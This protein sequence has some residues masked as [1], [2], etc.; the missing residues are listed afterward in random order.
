[1]PCQRSKIKT[2]KNPFYQSLTRSQIFGS[3]FFILSFL[4]GLKLFFISK[5]LTLQHLSVC[6]S[7]RTGRPR[8][9]VEKNLTCCQLV[10]VEVWGMKD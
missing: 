10:L 5:Y 6:T 9:F 7:H 4:Y 1:M 2:W 8:I 3:Y